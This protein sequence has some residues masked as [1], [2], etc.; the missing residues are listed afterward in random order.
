MLLD[1]VSTKSGLI[2]VL[3]RKIIETIFIF[4]SFT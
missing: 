3:Y 4:F 1:L 2:Y